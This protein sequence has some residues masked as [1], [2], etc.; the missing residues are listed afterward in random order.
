M[1]TNVMM[2]RRLL[3]RVDCSARYTRLPASATTTPVTGPFI[4]ADLP[5][6]EGN[7]QDAYDER[8]WYAH[9][10]LNAAVSVIAG[11]LF[12]CWDELKR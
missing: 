8:E 5:V 2:D 7:K 1:E 4:G 9:P 3:S 10:A 6:A 12:H 11:M